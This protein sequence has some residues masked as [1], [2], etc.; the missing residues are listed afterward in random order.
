MF[1]RITKLQSNFI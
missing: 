1:R